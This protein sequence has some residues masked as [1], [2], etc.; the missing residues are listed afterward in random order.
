MNFSREDDAARRGSR[1]C[2][3]IRA[4][5]PRRAGH[6]HDGV[7]LD[8]AG[9]RGDEGRR[10]RL[11][12]QALDQRAAPAVGAD[13]ARPRRR[14][15]RRGDAVA[16]REELDG[17]YD[18]G[19]LVGR[20]PAAAAG[21][22]RS[23]GASPPPTPRCSITGESGTGK[24]L[25]AEAIHRNSRRRSGPFVKVNLGGISSTLF[26]SEMFGHVRGRLHRRASRTARDASS[27]PHGGT[28]FLD[29]IGELDPGSPGEAA[30][31]AAGPRLRGAGLERA[32]HRR[33]ARRLGHQPQ[34]ARDGGD[35]R[36]PRGPALPDQP[37]RRPPAAAARARR[38]HPAPRAGA[39]RRA[40]GAVYGRETLAS[41][42]CRLEVAPSAALAGQRPPAPASASSAPCSSAHGTFSTWRTST[43]ATPPSEEQ[44]PRALPPVGSMTI[45]EIEK[46]MIV[47][48]HEVH[49]GQRHA[50]GRGPRPLAARP[51]IVVSR[52]TGSAREPPRPVRRLPGR[53]PPPLCRRRRPAAA[54]ESSVAAGRRGGLPPFV[55]RGRQ[56]RVAALRRP[57]P[58]C[59]RAPRISP[60]TTITTRIRE[61]GQRDL[62]ALIGVYN[63]MVDSLREER[64]QLQEQHHLLST[65]LDVSPSGFVTLDFDGRVDYAN[66]RAEVLLGLP[67]ADAKGRPLA[68]LGSSMAASLAALAP[69]TNGGRRAR[70]RST[71]Q[72]LPWRVRS[73]AASRAPSS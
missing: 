55:R 22:R 24:E 40:G 4:E 11:R 28:I 72:V 6:P 26:E 5:R 51:S 8:R 47:K 66:P 38:R 69:G 70:G 36:V 68:D 50:G 34:P 32:A 58:S 64:L 46:A 67:I 44:A 20:G 21:A 7:G 54:P 29:E 19:A 23:S 9:R 33:R 39:L 17:G 37:H 10:R 2:P 30:A 48:S 15:R 41:V 56:P 49:Q 57:R 59:G 14:G 3:R 73:T 65:V 35:R 18:F 45:D 52:S 63:R 60:R 1:S 61:I 16:T 43:A 53:P 27:S 62:D 42:G 71:R 13:G 31:R 12:H 25:V